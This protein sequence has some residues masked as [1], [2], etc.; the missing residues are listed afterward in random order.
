[1]TFLAP[2]LAFA[3]GTLRYNSADHT[4]TLGFHFVYYKDIGD[5]DQL[6]KIRNEAQALWSGKSINDV[7][8]DHPLFVH[9]NGDT[10]RLKTEITWESIAT[11]E[12][13]KRKRRAKNDEV[14]IEINQSNEE[15]SNADFKGNEIRLF[16]GNLGTN[17]VISH[18]LGHLLGLDHP[19]CTQQKYENIN[20]PLPGI[21]CPQTTLQINEK[22]TYPDQQDYLD[23]HFKNPI[24]QRR[25]IQSDVDTAIQS[26]VI[27]E[28]K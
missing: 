25:V 21:M 19:N 11:S 1:M 14:F 20:L 28:V 26:G 17:T 27:Q 2:T 7:K 12:V 13:S 6:E 4:A 23:A 16:G 8:D 22:W 9:L 24:S 5:L 10:Y 15:T 18:E 3:V